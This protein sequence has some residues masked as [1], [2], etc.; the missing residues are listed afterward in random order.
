MTT[1]DGEVGWA[2][3]EAGADAEGPTAGGVA[4]APILD[5]RVPADGSPDALEIPLVGADADGAA[6]APDRV[7][8][9]PIPPDAPLVDPDAG[10]VELPVPVPAP[11]PLVALAVLALPTVVPVALAV[12][13]LP[14]SVPSV[15]T[16]LVPPVGVPEPPVVGLLEGGVT[17]P[18]VD[19]G[20][21]LPTQTCGV[22]N[23]VTTS[24]GGTT[25]IVTPAIDV[26]PSPY[27]SVAWT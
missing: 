4:V 7:P 8:G 10:M 22:G 25:R 24:M 17:R 1:P 13:A 12:L 6:V 2:V 18:I 11:V 19:G 14:A 16:P 23:S 3:P 27:R 20:D 15:P 5:P 21:P 9:D 26:F